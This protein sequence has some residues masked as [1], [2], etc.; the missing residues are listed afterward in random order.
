VIDP[1][2]IDRRRPAVVRRLREAKA[3]VA[4]ILHV[5]IDDAIELIEKQAKEIEEKSPYIKTVAHVLWQYKEGADSRGYSWKLQDEEA[6]DLMIR[7]CHYCGCEPGTRN[8]NGLNGIDR[9]DNT[10]GY[11]KGNVVP[12]C[13]TCNLLKG[14]R[15]VDEFLAQIF[16]I[17]EFQKT[18][19]GIEK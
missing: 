3:S 7:P 13:G 2:N 12:C 17:A 10:R 8:K 14:A 5:R 15:T 19:R 4:E 6:F 18:A 1:Q 11:E 16:A 9:V